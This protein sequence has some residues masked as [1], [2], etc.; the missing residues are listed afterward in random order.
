[1]YFEVGKRLYS[2]VNILDYMELG[3]VVEEEFTRNEE[4]LWIRERGIE[5]V[6]K[7][8]SGGEIVFLQKRNRVNNSIWNYSGPGFQMFSALLNYYHT[9]NGE[10][11][12]MENI[13]HIL[14][15]TTTSSRWSYR[16]D[17]AGMQRAIK[18]NIA[19]M[20]DEKV[21]ENDK[22]KTV[23]VGSYMG[24]LNY[25][26]FI[27]DGNLVIFTNP[28]KGDVKEFEYGYE[29]RE[30]YHEIEGN[31]TREAII[32]TEDA[33]RIMKVIYFHARDKSPLEDIYKFAQKTY[34]KQNDEPESS[35]PETN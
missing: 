15:R 16:P 8:E 27:E 7:I 24:G 23:R 5:N 9:V 1:M 17:K 11:P 31:W 18:V 2:N 25:C 19:V 6:A 34:S 3:R 22:G 21:V 28:D 14:G 4:L 32:D 12:S 10:L 35:K 13:R 26:G 33:L 29:N 30:G 20:E